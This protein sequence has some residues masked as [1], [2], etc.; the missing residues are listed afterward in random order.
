VRRHRIT[1]D[2]EVT[3]CDIFA[4]HLTL[5]ERLHPSIVLHAIGKGIADDADYVVLF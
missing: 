1:R 2:R 3:D 5:N 4:R